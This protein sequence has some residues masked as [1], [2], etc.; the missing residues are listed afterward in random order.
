MGAP[1]D[2]RRIASVDLLIPT[3]RKTA[4]VI[5]NEVAP[6]SRLLTFTVVLWILIG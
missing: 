2:D 4:F 1:I 3:D 6:A 5:R